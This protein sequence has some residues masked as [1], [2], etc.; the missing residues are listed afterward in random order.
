MRQADEFSYSSKLTKGLS[1]DEDH[2]DIVMGFFTA[3][4]N[5]PKSGAQQLVRAR[6]IKLKHG[7]I[8][9]SSIP[10]TKN[11]HLPLSFLD[12]KQLCLSR[13]DFSLNIL[14]D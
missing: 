3:N 8:S 10:N 13:E 1:F 4:A 5:S 11:L 7:F 12:N 6:N 9:V 14:D 2:F